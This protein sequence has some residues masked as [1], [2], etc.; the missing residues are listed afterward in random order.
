MP[1]FLL[2]SI[3]NCNHG[4]DVFFSD[5]EE[6]KMKKGKYILIILLIFFILFLITAVSFFYYEFRKPPTVKAHSYLEFNLAGEIVE[7]SMPNIFTMIFGAEP[8][9]VY[10]IWMNI[11]KAKND[12][13]IKCLLLRLGYLNCDWAKISEIREAV[14]DF[15]KSGKKA[16]AYIE[17]APDIDKEYYLATACDEIILQPL[18]FLG[19][20]GIGGYIPFLKRTLD[21][22]GIEAEIEHVEEYKT[23]YNIFTEDKF[24]PAHKEMVESI[25][26]D[27]FDHYLKA[28]AEARAKSVEEMK[29]LINDGLFQGENALKS[30]LVDK[31][32]YEDELQNTLK[33]NGKKLSKINHDQYSKIKPT[34]LGLNR[35]KKIA[36]IY[37]MGPIYVGESTA[38]IMGS[39]TVSRWIRSTRK[40]N[41]IKAV[42]FRVDSPGGSAVGS[43]VIWREVSLTKKEKPIVVSM[44]DVAGSGGYWVSMAA[45]K[46]VA[47]PQTL[48]GSIGVLAGKF[49]MTELYE[50]L[51]VTSERLIYGERADVF[52]TFRGLTK[53]ERKSLKEEILWIYDQFLAKVAEGR[54]ITKEK[55][56]EIGRGRVWTGSQA[57]NLGLV[58]EIGGLSQAIQLAKQLAGIPEDEEV[59]LIVWPKEI[60]LFQ[61]LLA[62]KTVQTDLPR[63]HRVQNILVTLRALE[64]ERMWAVM[65]F[66]ILPD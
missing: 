20:N 14:L 48:T 35:G 60:S 34:S 6:D 61:A 28:V 21:K 13:R 22:L 31:L 33:H 23:A 51:G 45:N 44:S 41:S 59:K 49:N 62:R 57:K 5:E 7:K 15:K 30:G 55:V 32:L 39:S 52:S 8:L 3:H 64:K 24:T 63:D 12:E 65:P 66:W 27:I 58:D 37:G 2:Y 56:D 40:D 1:D 17:E 26:S 19:I 4:L 43:D 9:S 36:L 46:I 38:Q 50:K 25:Y 11:R 42:V 18:G 53:E 54:N 10:D 47:Q 29:T 16:Y